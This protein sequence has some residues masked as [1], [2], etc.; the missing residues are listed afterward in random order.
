MSKSLFCKM[1]STYQ[2]YVVASEGSHIF[3][4]YCTYL[5]S[6]VYEKNSVTSNWSNRLIC[7]SLT[8]FGMEIM[9]LIN[10]SS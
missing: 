3:G 7:T 1:M 5:L 9:I 10:D 4:D 6:F 8:T 2:K